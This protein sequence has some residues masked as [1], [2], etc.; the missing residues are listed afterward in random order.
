MV[1]GALAVI[2]LDH[3]SVAAKAPPT[4]PFNH[5]LSSKLKLEQQP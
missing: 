5:T 1:G 3:V 4:K 2:S